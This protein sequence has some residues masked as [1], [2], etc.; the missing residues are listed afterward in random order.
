[1][2]AIFISAGLLSGKFTWVTDGNLW[3][4]LIAAGTCLPYLGRLGYINAMKFINIS[5][6]SI[7]VQSQPFFAAAAALIILGTFPPLKEI[8]GGL[9]IVAGVI[10]IRLIE[11]Q[12]RM[13]MRSMGTPGI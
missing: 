9:L 2:S 12:V 6:A 7:I 11:R 1:M 10:V 13:K 5:R 4:I 3:L 8:I